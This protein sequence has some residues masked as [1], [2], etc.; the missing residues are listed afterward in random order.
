MDTFLHYIYLISDSFL[1]FFYRLTGIPILNFLIGTFC[2]AFICVIV[3]E[4]SISLGLKFNRR[5]VDQS[6]FLGS[7]TRPGIRKA[8]RR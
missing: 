1:I 7:P 8:T 5:Y 4:L 3:G 2:L 6:A